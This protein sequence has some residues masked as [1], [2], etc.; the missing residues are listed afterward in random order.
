MLADLQ[1][2]YGGW[3]GRREKDRQTERQTDRQI[4]RKGEIGKGIGV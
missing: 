4:I 2:C 1:V 3:T